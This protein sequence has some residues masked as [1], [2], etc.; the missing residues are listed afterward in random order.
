MREGSYQRQ[1]AWNHFS[2]TLLK[3][4]PKMANVV[5]AVWFTS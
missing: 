4:F 2:S 3:R 5:Q 1:S